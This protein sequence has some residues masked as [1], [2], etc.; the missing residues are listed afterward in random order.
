M[1]SLSQD[2]LGMLNSGLCLVHCLAMPLFISLGATFVVHPALEGVFVVWA[3]WAL[4]SALAGRP[5]GAFEV[6]LWSTW[7]VFGLSMLAEHEFEWAGYVGM[8]ASLG[9]IV[10]HVLNLRRRR[11]GSIA[12]CGTAAVQ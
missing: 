3:A 7:A 5:L 10:G 1:R 8:L 12:R 2:H 4:R 9:L 11:A 6:I